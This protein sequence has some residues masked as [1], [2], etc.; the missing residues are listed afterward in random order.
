LAICKKGGD[1]VII[2]V[3]KNGDDGLVGRL[4]RTIVQHREAFNL[5]TK[6][7]RVAIKVFEGGTPEPELLV[8]FHGKSCIMEACI[9]LEDFAPR[10]PEEIRQAIFSAC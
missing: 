1:K 8:V 9:T 10:L 6:D 3:Q 5:A 7:E 2:S 4:W